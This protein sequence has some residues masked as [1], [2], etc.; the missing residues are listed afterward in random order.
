MRKA[1][2]L[3]DSPIIDRPHPT[4]SGTQK[5]YRFPNGYGAS[6]V[7]FGMPIGRG[8]GSYTSNEKQWE[9]AVIKFTEP[10]PKDDGYLKTDAGESIAFDLKYDTP[11]TSDVIGYLTKA[12]VEKYLQKISKLA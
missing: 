3:F 1:K 4:G 2:K 11:I 9:L 6:V 7:R 10:D 12:Q 8:Y 5:V